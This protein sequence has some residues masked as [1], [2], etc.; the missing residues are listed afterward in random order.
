MSEQFVLV[1]VTNMR[2]VDLRVFEFD[3][4]L[5][6]AG[7]FMNAKDHVYGRYGARDEG[8][9]ESG[10]S[11][12]G[13]KYAM[14]QALNAHR[15]DPSVK[16]KSSLK[17]ERDKPELFSYAKRIKGD[18][19]IHCHQVHEFQ[20]EL[21]F[22]EKRWSKETMWRYPPPK[23]V[24][25]SLD[26]KQG[27]RVKSVERNSAAAKAGIE[28]GNVLVSLNGIPVSSQA[29]VH[30]AL[31][32]AP[33]AGGVKV[34][35]SHNG[36]S[37][38]GSL[39]L[40]R[41]RKQTDFSWRGSMWNTPPVP[42]VWGKDLTARQKKELGLAADR[43][44]FSQGGFVPPKT[45]QAGIRGNDII[46]GVDGKKLNLTML[47]FNGYIRENYNVGDRVSFDVIRNGKRIQI[48][49]TLP[50]HPRR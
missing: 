45:R 11:L 28:P 36:V 40:K 2:G 24:G 29:D 23:N 43:L 30:F 27:D 16:P 13:L 35:W 1:R 39:T 26:I 31:H 4:D 33:S 44:A 8:H 9:A 49:M 34:Q 48:E 12:A 21:A 15:R 41:G 42:G 18:G 22:D 5:T 47:Q 32:R 3:F 17:P 7:L 19:C 38:S 50:K 14:Q 37:R 20:T 25:L 10:L 6:W 46:V